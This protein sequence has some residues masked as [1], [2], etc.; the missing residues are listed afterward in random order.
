M[1]ALDKA[2]RFSVIAIA[3]IVVIAALDIAQSFAAPVVLGIVTGIIVS[4]VSDRLDRVGLPRALAA[5]MSFTAGVAAIALL[6]AIFQPAADR[7]ISAFPRLYGE[8]NST[9]FEIQA[10]LRG[11][12]EVEE[13]VKEMVDPERGASGESESVVPAEESPS[14]AIPSVEDVVFLAPS[15]AAQ[16]LIFLGTFFFFVLTRTEIYSFVARR[17]TTAQGRAELAKRLQSAER[18]VA[19]YFLTISGINLGLGVAVAAGMVAIGMPSPILWGV[20]AFILNF[21]I[22]LGPVAFLATLVV[23]GITVLDGFMAIAPALMYFTFNTIESQ[24]V[25]PAL[26]GKSL[27]V[28]PLLIFLTVTFFLWLWGPMGAIVAIPLL[29]WCIA[30]AGASQPER[31]E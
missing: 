21:L 24:F 15:I 9:L 7:A 13:D 11:L 19:R 6:V 2:T 18:Q 22:Y 17:L 28:N 3:F 29:L 8:L 26:L 14:D 25:T 20:A 4:P 30:L 16:V 10:Q 12:K 27:S 31:A 1:T 5:L 23:A